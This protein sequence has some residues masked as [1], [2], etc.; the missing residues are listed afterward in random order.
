MAIRHKA[1]LLDIEGFGSRVAPLIE[2]L[3][4]GNPK[5]LYDEALSFAQANLD[6]P[7]ILNRANHGLFDI[8]HYDHR[9]HPLEEKRRI[10]TGSQVDPWE[11]GYWF[12]II[13][14]QYLAKLMGIGINYSILTGVLN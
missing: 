6:K 2:Q 8:Q 7:W 1:F 4:S 9:G 12:L 14:S 13:L 3:D 11:I 10:T 5:P